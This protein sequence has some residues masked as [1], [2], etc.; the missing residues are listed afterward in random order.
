VRLSLSPVQIS[1]SILAST[2]YLPI[3]DPMIMPAPTVT[4][5]A[6]ANGRLASAITPG[7]NSNPE[8]AASAPNS[9]PKI[10]PANFCLP[11]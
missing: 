4:V 5:N 7:I 2:N 3:A 6:H 9:A 8:S 1:L 11:K 10:E